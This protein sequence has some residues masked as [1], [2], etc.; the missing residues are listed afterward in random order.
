M[1]SSDEKSLEPKFGPE[2][3]DAASD[4]RCD[5]IRSWRSLPGTVTS[6]RIAGSGGK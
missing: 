2:A 5:V 6:A 3:S 1:T 4:Q